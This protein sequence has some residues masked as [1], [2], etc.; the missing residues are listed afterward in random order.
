MAEIVD[1][2]T[3]VFDHSPRFTVDIAETSVPV[4]LA[5]NENLVSG[6]GKYLFKAIDHIVLIS[7]GIIMPENFVLTHEHPEGGTHKSV[8]GFNAVPYEGEP[9]YLQDIGFHGFV[10]IP[11]ENYEFALN[12][13][14][15]LSVYKAQINAAGYLSISVGASINNVSMVNVPAALDGKVFPIV[16]FIKILHTI[17]LQDAPTPPT[18]PLVADFKWRDHEWEEHEDPHGPEYH[19]DPINYVAPEPPPYY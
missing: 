3:T 2:L 6:S 9:L 18:P 1:I 11:M 5:L 8:L 4:T 10:T 19:N 14:C 7:A 17:P 15:N 13:F 12:I 16:P